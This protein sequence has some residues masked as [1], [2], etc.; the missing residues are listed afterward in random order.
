LSKSKSFIQ[1]KEE[2]L[3]ADINYVDNNIKDEKYSCS[4]CDQEFHNQRHGINARRESMVTNS[5][6]KSIYNKQVKIS[7][8]NPLINQP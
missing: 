7:N 3:D 6:N 1:D 5:G 2:N 8:P 4:N